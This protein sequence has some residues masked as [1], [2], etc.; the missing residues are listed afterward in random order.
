MTNVDWAL[1]ERVS[2]RFSQMLGIANVEQIRRLHDNFHLIRAV[3]DGRLEQCLKEFVPIQPP[4]ETSAMADWSRVCE[5]LRQYSVRAIDGLALESLLTPELRCSAELLASGSWTMAAGSESGSVVRLK[6]LRFDLETSFHDVEKMLLAKELVPASLTQLVAFAA[7]HADD[8][9]DRLMA[10][11]TLATISAASAAD[12]AADQIAC[13]VIQRLADGSG[14]EIGLERLSG[15]S[16]PSF[17]AGR[18]FLAARYPRA[19]IN[20]GC[21]HAQV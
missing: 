21:G 2:Q 8:L 14:F 1:I 13:P 3:M 4:N 16:T 12:A 5:R 19:A 18:I 15:L 20:K 7:E 10:T 11:G 6:L 9:P 17:E